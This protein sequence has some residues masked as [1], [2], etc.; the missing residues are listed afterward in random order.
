METFKNKNIIVVKNDILPRKSSE[1]NSQENVLKELV[2]ELSLSHKLK[3]SNSY[4]FG[5]LLD[6]T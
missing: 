1:I 2:K 3:C 4:I 5:T 6:L